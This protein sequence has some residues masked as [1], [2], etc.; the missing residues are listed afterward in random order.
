MT[1]DLTLPAPSIRT[2]TATAVGSEAID[3]ATLVQT[4]ATL[5]FRVA[6]SILR[7]PAESEDVVQDTFL[8]VLQHQSKL[9]AIRDL[10]VWLVRIAWN[11]ALDRRRRIRPDQIDDGLTHSLAGPDLPADVT[12][13]HARQRSAVLHQIDRLPAN[14]RQAILLSA[15]DELTIPEVAT[16]MNRSESAIRALLFRARTRLRDRLQK[17]GLA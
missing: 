5:L 8:R 7:N 14:E 12:L 16:I 1:E 9:P 11:L 10:R 6:H 15:L 4:Y 3:L 13:H 2:E 17:G